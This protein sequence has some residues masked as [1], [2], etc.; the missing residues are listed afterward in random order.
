MYQYYVT[1]LRKLQNG[2]FEHYNHFAWDEDQ[3]TARL[4]GEAKYHEVLAAAAVSEY[5]EHGAILMASDCTPIL[6]QCYRHKKIE[7]PAE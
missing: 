7:E 6:Y 3:D 1:E 5:L 2:E 4:K